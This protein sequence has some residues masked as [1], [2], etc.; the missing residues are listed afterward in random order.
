MSQKK[1]PTNDYKSFDNGISACLTIFHFISLSIYLILWCCTVS[2]PKIIIQ[3]KFLY[4]K[5]KKNYMVQ[6][7]KFVL[8]KLE[9]FY[10]AYDLLC[11]LFTLNFYGKNPVFFL[12][13]GYKWD[14]I[15][16]FN[17]FYSIYL[18]ALPVWL[19]CDK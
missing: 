8:K 5:K 4:P 12:F 7:S 1:L 6:I 18:F 14:E 17:I 19:R 13:L 16:Y 9:T 10:G 15:I 3:Y 2:T 11:Y